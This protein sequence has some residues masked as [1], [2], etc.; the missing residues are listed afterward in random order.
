M[1][2]YL[3]VFAVIA[4]GG[5][6]PRGGG[7]YR[8]NKSGETSV[9]SAENPASANPSPRFDQASWSPAIVEVN[10]RQVDAFKYAV[11]KGDTLFRI[12]S[13][14][15]AAMGRII[16]ANGLISP[17]RLE[18]G[19][20]LDIPA[21]RYHRV[22]K[23]ESGIAIARAYGVSWADVV[24]QNGI[25]YPYVLREGQRI[26]L[27]Q[28]VNITRDDGTISPEQQAEAYNLNIDDI[29]TGGQIAVAAPATIKGQKIAAI[30]SPAAFSGS[31]AWPLQGS[32][33]SQFGAK[34]GGKYNDGINIGA[35]SG[36]SVR[37]ASDGV[38]AYAGNGIDVYGGLVLVDHGGGWYSAYGHLQSQTVAAG[39]KVKQGQAIGTVG[40]SGYVDRPQLHFEIRKGRTPVDPVTKLPAR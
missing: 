15:G 19:Q 28:V 13:A 24:K 39:T 3:A 10:A 34:G 8:I 2:Q 11:Q 5:C 26:L 14:T 25:E 1:R 20:L 29:V 33:I 31:F 27:P 36:T 12:E 4:L 32:I 35:I 18:V 21:G 6:I 40:K 30:T 9:Q 23:G 16:E 22:G 37:A 7:D 38:V 17:Y